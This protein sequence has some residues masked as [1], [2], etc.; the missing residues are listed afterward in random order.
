MGQIA[1]LAPLRDPIAA[2][3]WLTGTGHDYFGD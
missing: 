2:I 1:Q 3:Y